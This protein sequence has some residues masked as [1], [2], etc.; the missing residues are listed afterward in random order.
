MQ[1]G[2]LSQQFHTQGRMLT[3]NK[4]KMEMPLKVL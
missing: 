2:G 1:H 3:K 4:N